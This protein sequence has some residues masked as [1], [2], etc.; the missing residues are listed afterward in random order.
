MVTLTLVR[1]G[2]TEW[3][4]LGRF[5]GWKDLPLSAVGRGQAAALRPKLAESTFA[6][7]WSSDLIRA[8]E[9]A[10]LAW[11]EPTCDSRLRELDFAEIEGRT[12]D[13]LDLADQQAL[14]SFDGFVAPGGE[15][16]A[17]LGERVSKFVEEL[18]PGEHLC[19]THGG[20]IRLLTRQTGAERILL[21]GELT[22]IEVPRVMRNSGR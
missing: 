5:L 13:N 3:T 14:V 21:P 17:S 6:G 20:V 15:S 1:H 11:G 4:S 7:V 8:I 18:E 22:T 19:F 10:R 9:T 2:E 12:W 16:V